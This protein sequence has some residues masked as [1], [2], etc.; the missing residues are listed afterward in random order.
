MTKFI[1]TAERTNGTQFTD[2]IYAAD[3]K[4]ARRDFNEIYRHCDKHK[5]ISVESRG[6]GYAATKEQEREALAEYKRGSF[7]L[8]CAYGGGYFALS[9][10]C[11]SRGN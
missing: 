11:R 5:I 2:T 1:I 4:A 10:G 6:D 7:H 3:E 9:D 8:S